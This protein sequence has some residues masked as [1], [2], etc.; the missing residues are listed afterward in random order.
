MYL[1]FCFLIIFTSGCAKTVTQLVTYG[2]E[3][4]V[5]VTLRGNVDIGA[6]RYFLIVSSDPAYKVPLPAPDYLEDAPELIEPGDTPSIGSVEA[7]YTNFYNTWSGYVILD[8]SGFTMVK[9]PFVVGTTPTREVLSSLTEIS[10]ILTFSFRLGRMFAT[11]PDQVYFD[12][13]TV[14][15]PDGNIKIP[16]DHLPSSN[17]YI[18]KI[19]GSLVTIDDETDLD[20]EASEDIVNCRV[21]I[22]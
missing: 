10:S 2:D 15:W 18:L 12:F 13:V 6:N 19:S 22:Q 9:G 5:E 16:T 8:P 17:N 4:V 11:V 3:M 21:E 1:V 20:L 14:P 7:Y